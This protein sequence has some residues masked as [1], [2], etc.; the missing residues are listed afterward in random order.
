MFVNLTDETKLGDLKLVK[1]QL[2]DLSIKIS[3]L[4]LI[5]E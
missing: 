2:A 1:C 5:F 3:R 4:A